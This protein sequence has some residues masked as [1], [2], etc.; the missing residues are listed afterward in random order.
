MGHFEKDSFVEILHSL[1][2]AR[3]TSGKSLTKEMIEES[4]HGMELSKQQQDLIYE[5][6]QMPQ[7]EAFDG[8]AIG[9]T[10]ETS[11]YGFFKTVSRRSEKDSASG[12]AGRKKIISSANFR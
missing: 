2:E 9:L 12:A 1:E 10:A 5:Y 4:F 6:L 11:R 8:G 3:K 7:K